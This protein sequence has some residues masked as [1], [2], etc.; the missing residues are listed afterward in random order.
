MAAPPFLPETVWADFVDPLNVLSG[1]KKP[2]KAQIRALQRFILDAIAN[3]EALAGTGEGSESLAE[4]QAAAAALR[5]G[6][7]EIYSSIVPVPQLNPAVGAFPSTIADGRTMG[8]FIPQGSTGAG[9]LVE[10]R[11]GIDTSRVVSL[12]GRILRMLLVFNV[13]ASFA[14]DLQVGVNTVTPS[15][16]RSVQLLSYTETRTAPTQIL[17][18]LTF[19]ATGDEIALS[20]FAINQTA[21]AQP[22]ADF[23]TLAAITARIQTGVAGAYTTAGD[24]NALLG[25]DRTRRTSVSEALQQLDWRFDYAK[26]YQIRRDGTGDFLSPAQAS[27]NIAAFGQSSAV[28]RYLLKVAAGTYPDVEWTLP[29]HV[30]ILGAGVGKAIIYANQPDDTGLPLVTLNS[31][32]R[33]NR[34]SRLR[35]LSVWV[36]NGRYA[37]HPDLSGT[38][39]DI[40]YRVE[41]CEF[42]HLGNDGARA[43]QT[44]IGGNPADV[45][46]AEH[47]WG[48]GTASGQLWTFER[49]LFRSKNEIG[50]YAHN[51]ANFARASKLILRD[52]RLATQVQ[53]TPSALG[54]S[55]WLDSL[56]SRVDDVCELDGCE[57]S[58]PIV[59]GA[60][61]W[62]TVAL[63]D[64]VA[65]R[66]EWKISGSGNTP[67]P[68]VVIDD[69][70]RALRITSASTASNSAVTV[71]GTAVSAILGTVVVDRG[72]GGL[73]G[74]VYGTWDVGEHLVGPA[75]DQ[76]ITSLGYRLGDCRTTSKALTVTANGVTA[77]VTFNQDHRAQSNATILAQING[78]L[79]ANASASLMWVTERYRPRFRDQEAQLLNTGATTIRRKRAVAT[80]TTDRSCRVMTDADPASFFAGVAYEDIRPGEWGRVKTRGQINVAMDL[81]RSDS[82]VFVKGDSFGVLGSDG[83]FVRN[84]TVALMA[85]TNAVDA[86]WDGN[87]APSVVNLDANLDQLG[88]GNAATK[89]VGVAGGVASFD[90]LAG[91]VTAAGGDASLTTAKPFP[92]ATPA[93]IANFL[94]RFPS[95]RDWGAVGDGV[96]DDTA[97]I[98][99]AIQ[100]C[101]NNGANGLRL[102]A[103]HK[104]TSTILV[105]VPNM[106]L[107]GLGANLSQDAGAF[108]ALTGTLVTWAGAAGG[109]VFRF[110]SPEG[111]NA[112]KM[113]GGGM[114]NVHIL[115][116]GTQLEVL[117]R[118]YGIYEYLYFHN[119]TITGLY[120]GVV[121][122]LAVARDPQRNVFSMCQHRALTTTG[123]AMIIDGDSVA[124]TSFNRFVDW[125]S[126]FQNGDAYI[127]KNS[128]NNHFLCIQANKA[129][130]AGTGR[131]MVLHGSNEGAERTARG[132]IFTVLSADDVVNPGTETYTYPARGNSILFDAG[133]GTKDPI[134]GDNVDI[135]WEFIN[136]KMARKYVDRLAATGGSAVAIAYA[137]ALHQ[138]GD[139]NP[140]LL[141]CDASGRGGLVARYDVASKWVFRALATGQI[142]WAPV[143]TPVDGVPLMRLPGLEVGESGPRILRS[144][145]RPTVA[146]P[147]G[148]LCLSDVGP[149]SRV[150]GTWRRTSPSRHP[151]YVSGKFYPPRDVVF[152]PTPLAAAADIVY[153]FPVVI[154]TLVTVSA[155][156]A[157]IV[158]AVAGTS[159]HAGI[160]ANSAGRPSTV[161]GRTA[162]PIAGDVAT[163]AT[164]AL[165]ANTVLE[166][167]VYWF[168]SLP[169][170]AIQPRT[171][172]T[173]TSHNMA[174]MIGSGTGANVINGTVAAL[175]SAQTY[176]G[177]LPNDLTG[178]VWSDVLT[179][180]AP[181]LAFS[182]P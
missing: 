11:I 93:T 9:A 81:D 176:A 146:A 116:G 83:R 75:L 149:F 180:V 144:T 71:T 38:N 87:A 102:M 17:V 140:F 145:A 18:D 179:A 89:N 61:P 45:W 113:T 37:C 182:V 59:I 42:L 154:D 77:T 88:L 128:D 50:F 28:R 92:T 15:T 143:E 1:A 106:T 133:N 135:T 19:Q 134:V 148:S 43:Y 76:N 132:N 160:Y 157:R 171:L 86:G 110:T 12:G 137:K 108:G 47:A 130:P 99:A 78:V 155:L 33:M 55:L 80:G 62:S 172:S 74:A 53:R 82:A 166:P 60:Q 95:V 10:Y 151:G 152:A 177:G 21:A 39:P 112:Q 119:P 7:G 6:F 101:A 173:L 31:A 52:C 91:K 44:S 175:S 139:L 107:Y 69:G 66:A 169:N 5:S 109:T 41:D 56:G 125:S 22:Q 159:M 168:A 121:A 181:V 36:R 63:E 57:L 100:A 73:Q 98:N 32:F 126:V 26:T 27:I 127:I 105:N 96:A 94:G 49:S 67:V 161:L 178:R 35:G 123:A 3:L 150:D 167:G 40:V 138:A 120:V 162:T 104:V 147:N 14:R 136:G 79:G 4:L 115:G 30:D 90:D 111:A 165:T 48:M 103:S 84:P 34:T 25:F 174:A 142:E 13:N 118:N 163:T 46:S 2:D 129:S 85:A 29:D 158:T 8:A 20:P 131:D 23:F 117:S 24:E 141:V 65:D 153:V 51:N 70:A 114:R 170:G 54:A 72:G 16:V 122:Q 164:A 97:A 156:A 64:Q 124:N 58:G 68:F